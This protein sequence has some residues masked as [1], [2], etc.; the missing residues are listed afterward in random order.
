MKIAY[1]RDVGTG[2]TRLASSSVCR[3]QGPALLIAGLAVFVGLY[4][5]TAD[6]NL[7]AAGASPPAS[8]PSE[9]PRAA[10]A[11]VMES[12]VSYVGRWSR[13]FLENELDRLPDQSGSIPDE[14]RRRAL[15]KAIDGAV[16]LHLGCQ[17]ADARLVQDSPDEIEV[18]LYSCAYP[19][20]GSSASPRSGNAA[21]TQA[22]ILP[23][24]LTGL[25]RDFKDEQALY[26]GEIPL[27]AVASGAQAH[28]GTWYLGPCQG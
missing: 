3:A 22:C 17:S 20:G 28:P 6:T 14:A 26:G 25:I 11:Y 12:F 4:G 19:A 24:A 9:A 27:K 18:R 2:T 21:T 15:R 7:P 1:I 23:A 8:S 16:H 10:Q 5:C 13:Q